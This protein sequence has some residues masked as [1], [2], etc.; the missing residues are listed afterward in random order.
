MKICHITS[1]HPYNDVRIFLKECSIISKDFETHLVA[2]DAPNGIENRVEIH[3]V[4]KSYKGRIS[5]MTETVWAVYKKA[6]FI[7]ADLYHFHDSE[8]IPVGLL[9]KLFGKKVI[10]DVHE[11]L[12]RQ[13]LSKNW[14]PKVLR[15]IISKMAASFEFIGSMAFDGI[16]AATPPIALRFPKGKTIVVQNYPMINELVC[17]QEIPYLHRNPV[18]VYIGGIAIIRGAKEI[19]SALSYIPESMGIRLKLAGNFSPP[20]FEQELKKTPGW[21]K[22]EYVGWQSREGIKEL[23]KEAKVGLVTLHP[24]PNYI[25][26]YPVK[27]FEYMAAGI[28]VIASDFPLWRDIIE[29]IGCGLLVNPLDTQDIAKAIQWVFE[30]PDEAEAMGKRG[31]EAVQIRYNW[32]DEANKL[33][34]FYKEIFLRGMV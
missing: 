8:L 29:G 3:N 18:V 34:A 23:L 31:R 28:P 26:S 21:E 1:V 16:V 19:I 14:I 10:Y 25:D 5:R 7:N 9:L 33:L 15:R 24:V 20:V 11:D 2:P 4:K 32:E 17:I 22:T 12:P 6:C 13:I 30:H 27:L